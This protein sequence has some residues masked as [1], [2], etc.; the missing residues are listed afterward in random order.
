MTT[1]EFAPLLEQYRAA[2]EAQITLLHHLLELAARGR[3]QAHADRPSDLHDVIDERERLMGTLVSLESEIQPIRNRIAGARHQLS[4]RA[5]FREI[6]ELH[7]QAVAL[8]D[9]VVQTDDQSRVALRDAELARRAT[10]ESLE[11][12]ESTIAAY[13][14]V[15][16]PSVT[17]AALVNRKG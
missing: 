14:R 4:R 11:K 2:L 7:Q 17:G 13:R 15:V 5:E 3:R 16:M 10:A 6:V 1:D 12:G 9:E 8:V